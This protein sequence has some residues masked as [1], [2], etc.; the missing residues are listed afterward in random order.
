MLRA[1]YIILATILLA[2]V[3]SLATTNQAKHAAPAMLLADGPYP[4]PDPI[5]TPGPC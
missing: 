4:Q 2:S 3:S 5:P 1:T